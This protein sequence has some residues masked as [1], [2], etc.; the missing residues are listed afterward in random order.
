MST[1]INPT[2]AT[3]GESLKVRA[4]AHKKALEEQLATLGPDD[5]RAR[6]EIEMALSQIEGLL[7]GDLDNIPKVV[8]VELSRWLEA[9]K[10]ISEPAQK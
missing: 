2:D 10:Y 7:T 9:S 8:A 3:R 1:L 4:I 5:Q 6:R